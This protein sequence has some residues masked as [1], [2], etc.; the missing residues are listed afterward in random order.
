MK[1]YYKPDVWNV[2]C[3][4]CGFQFKSDE[5]TKRWDGLMVDKDCWEPRHP[6]DLLKAKPDD[7]SVPWSAPFIEGVNVGPSYPLY[8]DE[9]YFADLYF[10]GVSSQLYL[11]GAGVDRD[12]FEEL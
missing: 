10:G 4:V 8:I 3:D 12:Y 5:L 6:Q 7:Q 9:E 1:S 2:I 11:D